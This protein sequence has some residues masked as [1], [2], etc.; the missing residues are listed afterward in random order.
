MYFITW[1]EGSNLSTQFV[2]ISIRNFSSVKLFS[3]K[4][5]ECWSSQCVWYMSFQRTTHRKINIVWVVVE[6]S[7]FFNAL[8]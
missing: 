1:C 5:Q 8:K 2:E 6:E 7:E 4:T 3:Q